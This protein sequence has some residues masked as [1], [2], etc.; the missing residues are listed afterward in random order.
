MRFLRQL[1]SRFLAWRTVR[2]GPR[3]DDVLPIILALPPRLGR[4]VSAQGIRVFSLCG[5]CG[6]RLGASATLCDDCARRD[7]RV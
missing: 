1:Y 2:Q 6:T 5:S 4:E 3:A 7:S